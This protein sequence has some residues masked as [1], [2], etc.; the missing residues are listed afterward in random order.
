MP[1]EL[2]VAAAVSLSGRCASAIALLEVADMP[3]TMD[4]YLAELEAIAAEAN[5]LRCQLQVPQARK[6]LEQLILRSLWQLLHLSTT[7][8]EAEIKRLERMIDVGAQ[9]QLGISLE[10]SQEIYYS[11]LHTPS[12]T[13]TP[14]NRKV[15]GSK[16]P[17]LLRLSQKLRVAIP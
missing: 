6:T 16:T 15:S 11:Y 8:L 14:K 17:S 5:H 13:Q 9:L 2:Q 1:Q 7:G 3:Q 4:H 10:R 12:Q